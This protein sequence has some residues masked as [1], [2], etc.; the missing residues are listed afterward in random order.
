MK[1]DDFKAI[2]PFDL[3]SDEQRQRISTNVNISYLAVG[4]VRRVSRANEET[5]HLIIPFKGRGQWQSADQ[6]AKV[7]HP[8]ES[9][10]H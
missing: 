2:P 7:I 10:A 3:L 5:A 6:E 1:P 4:Q 9:R 8:L